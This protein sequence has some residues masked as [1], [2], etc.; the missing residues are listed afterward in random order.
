MQFPLA[1]STP[2]AGAPINFL[3]APAAFSCGSPNRTGPTEPP[4]S[5][6]VAFGELT[7]AAMADED[8]A[9]I[10]SR[11]MG[12]NARH[13]TRRWRRLVRLGIMAFL[14][15]RQWGRLRFGRVETA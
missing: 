3:R 4:A 6:T 8:D 2:V 11:A 13:R 14:T 15:Q 1:S 5:T 9:T 10:P 7:A 12:T